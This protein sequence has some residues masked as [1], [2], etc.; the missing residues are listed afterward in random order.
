M[1]Y[2][3]QLASKEQ[4]QEALVR[5]MHIP[6]RQNQVMVLHLQ[7]TRGDPFG[8]YEDFLTIARTHLKKWTKLYFHS[9]TGPLEFLKQLHC[10]GF[11]FFIVGENCLAFKRS[12]QPGTEEAIYSMYKRRVV[13]ESD[14]PHLSYNN[15]LN[16]PH[17]VYHTALYLSE[18]WAI[19]L[20]GV[21]ESTNTAFLQMHEPWLL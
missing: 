12:L 16:Y 10:S 18:M 14:A 21:L 1:G 8:V 9:F 2:T 17:A 7:G 19:R 4:Q 5:F 3:A 11:P 20:K 13:I 15:Q 6:M